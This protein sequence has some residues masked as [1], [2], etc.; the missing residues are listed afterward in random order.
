M[1]TVSGGGVGNGV[2]LLE[3]PQRSSAGP[4]HPDSVKMKTIEWWEVFGWN[5]IRGI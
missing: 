2:N 3:D 5:N 1:N 4:S